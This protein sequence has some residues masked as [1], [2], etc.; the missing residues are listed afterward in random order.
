MPFQLSHEP[1]WL[2]NSV[3]KSSSRAQRLKLCQIKFNI[4]ANGNIQVNLGARGINLYQVKVLSSN[5]AKKKSG[6][7][8]YCIALMI[9]DLLYNLKRGK[10]Q[11]SYCNTTVQTHVRVARQLYYLLNAPTM[12]EF[13]KSYKNRIQYKQ[14]SYDDKAQIDIF[15]PCAYKLFQD[16]IDQ[17]QSLQQSFQFVT[18][19]LNTD[20]NDLRDLNL[21]DDI[22]T[23]WRAIKDE[24]EEF[25]L[26]NEV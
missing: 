8:E 11:V 6:S 10:K 12:E 2:D 14:V 1:V 18:E 15:L 26:A 23:N 21:K 4:V 20:E 3:D 24:L 13:I 5:I 16:A 17:V 7:V 25:G 22:N 19:Y 9:Y